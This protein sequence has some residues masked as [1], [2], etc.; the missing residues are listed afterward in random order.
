MPTLELGLRIFADSD[1]QI[2]GL[3]P[4]PVVL[5]NVQGGKVQ[6]LRHGEYIDNIMLVADEL[7]DA[8]YRRNLLIVRNSDSISAEIYQGFAQGKRFVVLADVA[9]TEMNGLSQYAFLTISNARIRQFKIGKSPGGMFS[10]SINMDSILFSFKSSDA[11]IGYGSN[12]SEIF[13]RE[14]MRIAGAI[15]QSAAGVAKQLGI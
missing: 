15:G 13:K 6:P 9:S 8:I 7:K 3:L 2:N 4:A 5:F 1:T 10:N 11:R 12:S 14:V